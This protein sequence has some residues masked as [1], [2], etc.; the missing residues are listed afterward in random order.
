MGPVR[1]AGETM[2]ETIVE[3]QAK[4]AAAFLLRLVQGL[5]PGDDPAAKLPLGQLRVC[6]ALQGGR[7]SMSALSR[8]LGVSLPAM[9]Q[10]ADRLEKARLVKRVAETADR[11]VR[12][13]QL[14]ERGEKIMRLREEGRVRRM[15]VL[16]ERLSPNARQEVLDVLGMMVRTH[17]AMNGEADAAVKGSTV[18]I[19]GR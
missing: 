17:A 4:A 11:R 16:L 13:L 5:F 12:C 3:T 10:I 6:S 9:T 15:S 14:T 7:R 2:S 1:D 18:V 19:S 8:K